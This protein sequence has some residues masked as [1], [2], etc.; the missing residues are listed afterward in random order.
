MVS[1]ISAEASAHGHLHL[2][3]SL[4]LPVKSRCEDC[5]PSSSF[6]MK[7]FCCGGCCNSKCC[8][9]EINLDDHPIYCF[10]D[11]RC[12]IFD[13]KKADEPASALK[14]SAERVASLVAKENRLSMIRAETGVD[15]EAKI[16]DS[17]SIT[18][19]EIKR[20]QRARSIV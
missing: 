15:L 11:G 10:P 3:P 5:C 16:K 7:I 2:D 1:A 6:F 20:L 4:Q 19:G 13:P 14:E 8:N 9:K 12:V 17:E 18:I